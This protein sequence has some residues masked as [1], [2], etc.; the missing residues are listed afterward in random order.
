[1]T[2]TAITDRIGVIDVDSHIC[3]PPD[4][5]VSRLPAKWKDIAPRIVHMPTGPNGADEEVWVI[6]DQ[7]IMAGWQLAMAGWTELY[8]GHPGHQHEADPAAWDPQVRVKT[9][10]EHGI[11][12]QILYPNVLA[13]YSRTMLQFGDADFHLACVRAYNDFLTDFVAT[14]PS[15]Y[16]A[17]T[18]LPFWD[19]DQSVA[20]IERCAQLGHRGALFIN[21]P[22]KAGLPLLPDPHWDKLF[23][24]AEAN[25]M[26]IN[27]H[28]AASTV[29]PA[30]AAALAPGTNA[31][32]TASDT[33][34]ATVAQLLSNSGAIAEVIISGLCHRYPELNFVSVESGFG[35]V[36]YLLEALDWQWLNNGARAA[37]P[38]RLMPSEYFRRQVYATF[39]F[40]NESLRRLADLFPDNLMFE[41]D[42]PHPTCLAP[43]PASFTD[44]AKV[45]LEQGLADLPEDLLRKILHENAARVYRLG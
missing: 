12:A 1:V 28:V 37:Y 6:G 27:F 39:W 19:T 17:I 33:V 45:V 23:R 11:A 20:E 5:W 30:F 41:T 14:A 10:D 44:S 25:R 4:L 9:L 26:S 3:E 8:P 36:P 32:L 15:R 7:P 42:F 21:A 13:F 16:G 35:Y 38:D 24:A 18:L 43:G 40:E 29:D 22:Q 31:P 2:T 34:M